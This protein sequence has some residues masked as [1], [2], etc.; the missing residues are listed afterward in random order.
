MTMTEAPFALAN[1]HWLTWMQWLSYTGREKE[2]LAAARYAPCL[3]WGEVGGLPA[4]CV[5]G[6]PAAGNGEPMPEVA[7]DPRM[8][9]ADSALASLAGQWPGPMPEPDPETTL[10]LH[11]LN[12]LS[13]LPA[14]QEY[15]AREGERALLGARP[16]NGLVLVLG[17]GPSLAAVADEV[18]KAK[19]SGAVI[20]AVNQVPTYIDPT[21]IDYYVVMS[22]RAVTAW[23]TDRDLR[24]AR[25]FAFVGAPVAIQAAEHRQLHWFAHL[26]G[27]PVAKDVHARFPALPLVQAG[28]TVATPAFW[29]A[30]QLGGVR[31]IA[32]AGFDLSFPDGMERPDRAVTGR[33][34][35]RLR[36]LGNA[37]VTTDGPL[38]L[39]AVRLSLFSA[40]LAERRIQVYNVGGQGL[41]GS[42]QIRAADGR[43]LSIRCATLGA[44]L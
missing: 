33:E 31:R 26:D 42:M 3:S 29:L 9:P 14:V 2:L 5:G 22:P 25:T 40:F 8:Y 17:S 28:Q 43:D 12:Y 4:A 30:A 7:W 35:F 44:L 23:W 16:L 19:A 21:L 6:Q 10:G 13:N 1:S 11:V 41:L 24:N 27:G 15:C 39:D 32:L 37:L 18:R 34:R 38:F 36:G 20:V